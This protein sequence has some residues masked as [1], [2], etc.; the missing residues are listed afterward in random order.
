M[1]DGK[2]NISVSLYYLKAFHICLFSPRQVQTWSKHAWRNSVEGVQLVQISPGRKPLRTLMEIS[3]LQGSVPVVSNSL[4]GR[5]S[6]RPTLQGRSVCI[7]AFVVG[8]TY[9][10]EAVPAPNVLQITVGRHFGVTL[11]ARNDCGCLL[12]CKE[13]DMKS[14]RANN[15]SQ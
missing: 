8:D 9:L 6:M 15:C 12:N 3:D 7:C 14:N 2:I 4:A 10:P 5:H 13:Q 1:T 11:A